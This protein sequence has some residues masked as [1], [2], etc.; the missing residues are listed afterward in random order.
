M[1]RN[2]WITRQLVADIEEK[3][4]TRTAFHRKFSVAS[5]ERLRLKT[6]Q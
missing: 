4:K 2:L 3:L 6:I 1:I 5:G